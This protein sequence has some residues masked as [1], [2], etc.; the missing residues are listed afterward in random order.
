[1][2]EQKKARRPITRGATES[3]VVRVSPATKARLLEMA[4]EGNLSLS[5]AAASILDMVVADDAAA[6]AAEDALASGER[7]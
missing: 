1:M 7:P 5:G 2:S 4:A 3:L 6:H